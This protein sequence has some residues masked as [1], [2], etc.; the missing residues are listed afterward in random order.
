MRVKLELVSK[1]RPI[2][3]THS[4][5]GSMSMFGGAFT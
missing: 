4:G 2:L 1:M 3:S 5:V